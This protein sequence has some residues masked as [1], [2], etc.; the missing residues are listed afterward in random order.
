V[1]AASF[2]TKQLRKQFCASFAQARFHTAWTHM[3]HRP[4]SYC[5]PN[6]C[7]LRGQTQGPHHSDPISARPIN[8]RWVVFWDEARFV[9]VVALVD[10]PGH[11]LDSWTRRRRPHTSRRCR[12]MRPGMLPWSDNRSHELLELAPRFMTPHVC[13]EPGLAIAAIRIAAIPNSPGA[14]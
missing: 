11:R 6:G 12:W 7:G 1:L 3:R 4:H 10:K 13:A 14:L 5:F 9:S 2:G 8:A